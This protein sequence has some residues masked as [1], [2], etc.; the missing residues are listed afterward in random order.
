MG[1]VYVKTLLERAKRSPL[2]VITNYT[3]PVGAIALLSPYTRQI[4]Y[5]NF[6]QSNWTDI[7]RFSGVNSG[8]LPLLRTLEINAGFPDQTVP[9]SLSLF[10]SAVNLNQFVLRSRSSSFL[11][12]F[13]FPNLTMFELSITSTEGFRASELLNFLEVSPVLRNVH[14]K[15]IANISLEG[16]V[17]GRVVTLPSV[18]TFSLTMNGGVSGYDLAAHISCPSASHT[19]LTQEKRAEDMSVGQDMLIFP[20]TPS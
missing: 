3:A 18:R 2:E 15:I 17:R 11:S 5:L 4:A 10:S 7:Q 14:M 16:V 6:I 8:P 1:E 20:T 19:L 13:V 12:H 9:A